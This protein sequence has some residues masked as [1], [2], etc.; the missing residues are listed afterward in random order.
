MTQKQ[1]E[2]TKARVFLG[3]ALYKD[4]RQ[5]IEKALSR[6]I[7]YKSDLLDPNLLLE[8]RTAL[9]EPSQLLCRGAI[10]EFQ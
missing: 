7:A 3:E 8:S 10:C 4:L 2:E 9:S 5:W 6:I 1:I